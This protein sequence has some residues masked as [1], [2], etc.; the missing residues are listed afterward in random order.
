MKLELQT[1]TARSTP[2]PSPS[3]S[4]LNGPR[5]SAQL[6]GFDAHPTR[7]SEAATFVQDSRLA[8]G[9]I[10]LVR[11]DVV[12]DVRAAIDAGTFERDIDW[13]AAIDGLLADL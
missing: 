2:T 12:R 13:N 9:T 7:L 11:E 3:A 4:R 1:Q 8:G 5:V 6:T 10:P